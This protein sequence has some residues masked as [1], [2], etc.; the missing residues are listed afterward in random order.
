MNHYWRIW[1]KRSSAGEIWKIWKQEKENVHTLKNCAFAAPVLRTILEKALSSLSKRSSGV[2]NSRTCM[3]REVAESD[4]IATFII[5]NLHNF[6]NSWTYTKEMGDTR[7]KTV[8]LHQNISQTAYTLVLWS[9][10]WPKYSC[11]ENRITTYLAFPKTNC[12][13]YTWEKRK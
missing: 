8:Y 11:S 9:T 10:T 7:I 1:K 13:A 2:S 6:W 3:E 5:Y 12:L 4:E